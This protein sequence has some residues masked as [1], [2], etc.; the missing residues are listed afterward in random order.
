M[1]QRERID[2]DQ[3]FLADLIARFKRSRYRGIRIWGDPGAEWTQAEAKAQGEAY[4]DALAQ[5]GIK[6]NLNVNLVDPDAPNEGFA[7]E[8]VPPQAGRAAKTR[9]RVA[10]LR[11]AEG[12]LR[13]LSRELA[14]VE[15]ER[16]KYLAVRDAALQRLTALEVAMRQAMAAL[17]PDHV[18]SRLL[19][20]A[21][22]PPRDSE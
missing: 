1:T 11:A 4:R 13:D 21:L 2:L 6:V 19:D 9:P 18:A 20:D 7:A 14:E 15:R 8:L 16:D 3:A 12:A 5:S 22:E 17:P 10:D